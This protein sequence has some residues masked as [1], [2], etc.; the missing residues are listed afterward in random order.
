MRLLRP[1]VFI[2][3]CLVLCVASSNAGSAEPPDTLKTLKK[4][5]PRLLMTD[6]RLKELKA[7]HESDPLLRA[8]VAQAIEAADRDLT[9]PPLAYEIPDGQRLLA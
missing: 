3:T 1:T 8:Y 2:A 7:I 4:D 9:A 5:H 6:E